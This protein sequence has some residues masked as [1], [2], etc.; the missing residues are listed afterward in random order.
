MIKKKR[1]STKPMFLVREEEEFYE[2]LIK[3]LKTIYLKLEKLIKI[4]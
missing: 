3:N 2:K 4:L 1:K